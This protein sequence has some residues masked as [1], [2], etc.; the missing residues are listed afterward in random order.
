MMIIAAGFRQVR[1]SLH[2][3]GKVG[4]IHGGVVQAGVQ[5]IGRLCEIACIF[6]L[7]GIALMVCKTIIR[8]FESGCRLQLPA[9]RCI[10]TLTC[11]DSRLA[12]PF[13]PPPWWYA[14]FLHCEG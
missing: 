9:S 14:L 7:F 13:E 1:P 4:V 12:F 8:R 10:F 11:A 3:S 2:D 5:D 6:R